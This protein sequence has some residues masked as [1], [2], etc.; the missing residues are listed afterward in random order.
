[1]A[2]LVPTAEY[3]SRLREWHERVGA[4]EEL[5]ITDNGRPVVRV[6]PAASENV[7]DRLEAA[8][9]LRRGRPRR[10]SSEIEAEP[11][12]GDSAASISADRDR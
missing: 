7:L 2:T 1:M 8:G 10:P 9:L 3:R 5:V 6:V 12:D 11:V 4:G